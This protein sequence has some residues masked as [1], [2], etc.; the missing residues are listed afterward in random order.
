[1][2]LEEDR[3]NIRIQDLANDL[4]DKV[5]KTKKPNYINTLEERI[6]ERDAR[7]RELEEQQA[8]IARYL[9]LP[10]FAQ[11]TWVSKYDILRLLGK[12]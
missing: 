8:E 9:S 7:I 11:E 2:S 4:F 3:V 12:Y 1:M 6:Q 5:V 10:K